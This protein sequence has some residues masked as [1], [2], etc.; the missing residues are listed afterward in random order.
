MTR[1]RWWLVIA[2]AL[3]ICGGAVFA[4]GKAFVLRAQDPTAVRMPDQ[5]ALI[6]FDQGIETLAIETRFVSKGK[7]FAWV[8]PLQA[9]PSVEVGTNGL[10]PTLQALFQPK[11]IEREPAT[12]GLTIPL[13]LCTLIVI[14]FPRWKGLLGAVALLAL[15]I[16]VMLPALGKARGGPIAPPTGVEILSRDI[17]GE[18]ELTTIASNDPNAL[19]NWLNDGGYAVPAGAQPVIAD[20]VARGWVFVAAKAVAPEEIASGAVTPRPLIFRFPVDAPVYPMC[21]TGV[22]NNGP[23]ELDLYVF[24]PEAAS[25]SGMRVTTSLHARREDAVRRWRPYPHWGSISVSHSGLQ[26]V[27]GDSLKTENQ[28]WGTKLTGVF[29]PEDMKADLAVKFAPG[30]YKR[31]EVYTPKGRWS[32]ALE[33]GGAL[34]V[35]GLWIAF[36]ACEVAKASSRTRILGVGAAFAVAAV[37]AFGHA[38]TLPITKTSEVV[39]RYEGYRMWEEVQYAL[40]GAVREPNQTDLEFLR[41]R[42]REAI[43]QMVAREYISQKF[44]AGLQEGD[45]PGCYEF[46]NVPEVGWALVWHDWYGGEMYYYTFV[47]P[48]AAE[49]PSGEKPPEMQ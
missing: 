6:L 25:V 15:F 16:V 23:L 31:E 34:S 2:L 46:R 38:A 44:A 29:Q 1:L 30:Q 41:A 24:G 36:L 28:L 32:Q 20:Y 11:V 40:P 37:G 35:I 5:Q 19:L 21:L 26:D 18:F 22:D 39:S 10:F 17:A 4:D 7:D 33:T 45:G 43:G 9:A 27:L 42:T 14:A 13:I 49:S 47:L 8:I 12:L 48:A 3:G